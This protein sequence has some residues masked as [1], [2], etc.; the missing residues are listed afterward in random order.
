[1][2]H[3]NPVEHERQTGDAAALEEE[4]H[5]NASVRLNGHR[6]PNDTGDLEQRIGVTPLGCDRRAEIRYETSDW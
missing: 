6:S 1:L 2:G 4:Q 5:A 3:G